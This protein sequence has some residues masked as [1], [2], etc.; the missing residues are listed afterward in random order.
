MTDSV[1]AQRLVENEVMFRQANEQVPKDLQEL[2][3]A[4]DADGEPALARNL[5]MPLHFY[6]ECSDENCRT[7]IK[8]KPSKYA[9]LHQNSSQFIV[10]PGHQVVAIEKIILETPSYFVVEKFVTPPTEANQLNRTDVD[11]N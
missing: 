3:R 10:L 4:S 1:Q 8:L 9:E 11:N 7:R 2:K 5:D 6:C